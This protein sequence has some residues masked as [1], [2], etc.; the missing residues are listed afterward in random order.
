M[1][2]MMKKG[3]TTMQKKKKERNKR[4]EFVPGKVIP[5]ETE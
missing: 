4:I 5:M 1:T 3:K 2:T